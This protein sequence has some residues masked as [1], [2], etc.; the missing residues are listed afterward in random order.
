MLDR[1]HPKSNPKFA[2]WINYTYRTI[3]KVEAE[4]RHKKTVMR[5]I[6]K[7]VWSPAADLSDEEKAQ[8][9]RGE[10]MAR[11]LG[12]PVSA[13]GSKGLKEALRHKC[14][15][16]N[17]KLSNSALE[18]EFFPLVVWDETW[19]N[20]GGKLQQYLEKNL[21]IVIHHYTG[22]HV[23]KAKG[24][25]SLF[26]RDHAYLG[27][28]MKRS[29]HCIALSH[30]NGIMTVFIRPKGGLIKTCKKAEHIQ[31][32]CDFSVACEPRGKQRPKSI[33]Y[34]PAMVRLVPAKEAEKR[35]GSLVGLGKQSDSTSTTFV[36]AVES[37]DH[38]DDIATPVCLPTSS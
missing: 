4:V 25:W 30:T 24:A 15:A 8:L 11:V 21:E 28:L 34:R 37:S 10:E 38:Y 33:D 23:L 31:A 7:G 5:S 29:E 16:L 20:E 27:D 17:V 18:Q 14:D 35:G 19:K 22:P 6:V 36:I 9:K 1:D 32:L 26:T 3:F 2:S 13:I 12:L